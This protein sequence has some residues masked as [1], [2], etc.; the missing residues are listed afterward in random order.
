[1]L[2]SALCGMRCAGGLISRAGM[3]VMTLFLLGGCGSPTEVGSV[4]SLSLEV[5]PTSAEPGD[6][7]RFLGIAHNPTKAVIVTG[8]GCSPGIGFYVTDPGGRTTWIYDGVAFICPELDSQR[9]EPGETDSVTWLWAVPGATGTY[10]A[11]A[12]LDFRDGQTSLSAAV[13]ILVE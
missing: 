10:Q 1:M 7:I 12:S 2:E 13:S 9:L 3:A 11:R 8:L 6:T 4:V 5:T